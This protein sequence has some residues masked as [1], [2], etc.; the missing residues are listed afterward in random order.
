LV[1]STPPSQPKS[2]KDTNWAKVIIVACCVVLLLALA[3]GIIDP[4]I[5]GFSYS[6]GA[7]ITGVSAAGLFFGLIFLSGGFS[8]LVAVLKGYIP[9]PKSEKISADGKPQQAAATIG[10]IALSTIF[11][12]LSFVGGSG[13][14]T[15]IFVGALGGLVYELAQSNGAFFMPTVQNGSLYLGG[16]FGL[17]GGGVA[18]VLLAQGLQTPDPV[19]FVLVSQSFLAGA[20]FKGFSEAVAGNVAIG[21]TGT[22]TPSTAS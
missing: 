17:I 2:P 10:C 8:V 9:L 11:A 16:L 3:W 22:P 12:A 1:Q 5:F 18:G 4:A 19:S 14:L 7:V 13:A 21:S 15:A 6:G 20:T